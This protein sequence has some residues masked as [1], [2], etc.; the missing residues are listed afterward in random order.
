MKV[1]TTPDWPISTFIPFQPSQRCICWFLFF[2]LALFLLSRWVNSAVLLSVHNECSHVFF[3]VELGHVGNDLFFCPCSPYPG[4]PPLCKE[5]LHLHGRV[6]PPDVFLYLLGKQWLCL[7]IRHGLC[8][9]CGHLPPPVLF[10]HYEWKV[11]TALI[12]GTFTMCC[13]FG[14]QITILILRLPFCGNHEINHF[15]CDFPAVLK[16]D[17]GDTHGQ[18]TTFILICA[19]VLTIP[20][21]LVSVSYIFIVM[22]ILRISTTSSQQRAFSTCSSHLMVVIMQY[23]C[24]SL[25]YLWLDSA[26]E[27]QV[28]SIFRTFGTPVLNPL[29]YTMRNR[30]LKDALTKILRKNLLWKWRV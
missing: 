12:A 27:N 5:T 9:L 8:P 30:E 2:P 21:L 24:G 11:C 1:K 19:I 18:W 14:M 22:A 7:A 23:S 3:L 25:V 29:I 4:Q 17:C 15:S 13:L 26:E 16:L 6:W 20:F 28:V 10:N